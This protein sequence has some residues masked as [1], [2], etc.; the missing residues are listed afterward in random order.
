MGARMKTLRKRFLRQVN[1]KPLHD[2]EV[3]LFALLHDA[4]LPVLGRDA[5]GKV[6]RLD[7]T[8]KWR[9]EFDDAN[10]KQWR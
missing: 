9:W 8:S 3:R 6:V 7:S 1:R 10:R 2:E 4:G 5:L